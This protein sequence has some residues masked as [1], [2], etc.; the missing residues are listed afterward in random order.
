MEPFIK[1][2]EKRVEDALKRCGYEDNVALS[3]SSRPDL[4]QFQYNGVMG[5]AKRLRTNPIEIA[6]KLVEEL[7]NDEYFTNVNMAGPG[8]INLSF[9]NE[10]L[11]SF[12]NTVIEDFDALVDKKESKNVIIDYGGANA[13]KALHVGHMRSANIGEALKR[14]YRLV[15]HNIIGDVHLGD[16]G[17]Q[18]GMVISELK[19]MYPELAFFKEN[20][21]GSNPEVKITPADLG[22]IYPRASLA[23]KEDEERME[24]VREITALIDKGYKPYL[25]LWKQIIAVSSKDIKQVYDMLNC[26]FDLW[27]G[28]IDSYKYIPATME[29]L[30]PHLYESEGA[31]VMDVKEDD[32]KVEIPPLIVIKKDGSTIYATRDLATIHSRVERF[33]PDEICYVV[34]NR[35]GLYFKQVFRSSYKSG[36]V[37]PET[38]LNF[39]G[40]GT[41]NGS[42]GKPFKTRDGGVMELRN[43][44]SMVEDVTYTKL[45]ENII[46]E[47]RKELASKL[48]IAV[49][50]YA[51]L[52]PLR[53]TDYIFDVEKFSS[54][55]G[56]TGPYI[57][58]TA[59]RINSIFSKLGDKKDVYKIN[60]VYSE[61]ELN[62]YLKLVELTKTIDNSF[63]ERTLSYICDYLFNLANLYN[64][65]YNEHNIINEER[66]EVQESYLALSKLTY[67]VISK[68]LNVLAIEVIDKM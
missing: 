51:D 31:L 63:N 11:V 54:L 61:E 27:E 43:L 13:A 10:K 5:I 30:N 20:Y 12:M 53:N 17:R 14:L 44:V 64:K 49:L 50:K 16:V 57:L 38:E 56:K 35:Q 22:V 65:F 18:A 60:G 36:L 55:E 48:A 8:F 42:D 9:N 47:E 46:G 21:D 37:K 26:E 52:L 25:D 32:D 58:Y 67:N 40:F 28:E 7:N 2:V 15:G 34:D 1:I 24:E 3:V 41:M 66:K 33:N 62:I 45:K 68:L 39:Y 59:V 6:K 23:A 29:V 4:G 19:R